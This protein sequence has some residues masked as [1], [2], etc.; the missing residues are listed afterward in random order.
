M[1]ELEPFATLNVGEE[2]YEVTRENATL[3]RHL[4]AA[5]MI[6]HLFVSLGENSGIYV[7]QNNPAYDE[8]AA[9]AV[10][11]ECMLIL[12]IQEPSEMDVKAFIKHH[13]S[14]LDTIPSWLPEL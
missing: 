2:K 11:N 1:S 5:A 3:Y 8:V 14:D 9:A 7:W 10:A 12:N 4:G 6:D 13:K